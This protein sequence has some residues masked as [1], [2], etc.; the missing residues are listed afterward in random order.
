MQIDEVRIGSIEG[1]G[2][3]AV[4]GQ[5]Q[6][7]VGADEGAGSNWPGRNPIR[8][9]HVVAQHVA[10]QGQLVLGGSNR[11]GI[12]HRPRYVVNH[13]DVQRATG[14]VAI[15]V[16]D[17]YRDAFAEP[18][19]ASTARVS[20][21]NAKGITVADHA[22][23]RV[24]TGDGQYIAK[25]RGDRLANTRHR[26]CGDNI[27]ATNIE[28]EH[29]IRCLHREAAHLGQ[30]CGIAGRTLSQIGLVQRQLTTLDVKPLKADRIV[31][32]RQRRC[33]V[34]IV[35]QANIQLRQ[36]GKAVEACSGKANVWI[37]APGHLVE[38]DEGMPTA[39]CPWRT[40]AA[41]PRC[42][43]IGFLARVGASG[44]GLLEFLDIGQLRLAGGR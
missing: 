17:Q 35:D 25:A 31:D 29:T 4:G 18:I 23:S 8:P 11:V 37:N 13:R 1:V 28:V 39:Q 16:T 12:G 7:A 24:I 6:G 38:N 2:V 27:D 30:G 21:G 9:L 43:G 32:R 33:I 10:G 20:V 42:S 41:W 14:Y 5:D 3:G 36:F 22:S 19:G 44:D 34:I 26:P 15:G 40:T